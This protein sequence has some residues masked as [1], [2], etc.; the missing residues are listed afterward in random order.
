[1]RAYAAANAKFPH[2]TTMNQ[3]FTESQF[4]SYRTL[5]AH[6]I[7]MIAD[8][9]DGSGKITQLRIIGDLLEF[10]ARAEA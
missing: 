1:V 8:K 9:R 3:W 5:G 4:E 6:A 10:G 2:D 7:A